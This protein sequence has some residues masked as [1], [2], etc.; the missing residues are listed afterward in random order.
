MITQT[1]IQIIEYVRLNTEL[2]EEKKKDFELKIEKIKT[3]GNNFI[4][5]NHFIFLFSKYCN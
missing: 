2:K 5:F 1:N 4:K 3:N